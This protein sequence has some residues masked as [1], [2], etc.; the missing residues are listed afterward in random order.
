MFQTIMDELFK[1]ELATR[2]MVIYMDD[3]LIAIAGTL[4]T[5]K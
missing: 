1:E 4:D 2:N 3:I 5:H